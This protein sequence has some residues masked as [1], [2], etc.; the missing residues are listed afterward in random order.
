MSFLPSASAFLAPALAWLLPFPGGGT[1][2]RSSLLA[3]PALV[4]S[5]ISLTISL[6]RLWFASVRKNRL[7]SLMTCMTSR[8]LLAR[9][10]YK[11]TH[12][13]LLNITRPCAFPLRAFFFLYF[14][15][16]VTLQSSLSRRSGSA[17]CLWANMTLKMV[18]AL[19]LVRSDPNSE[20]RVHF[21][22][23][24]KACTSGKRIAVGAC[25]LSYSTRFEVFYPPHLGRTINAS[26]GP[27]RYRGQH[28]VNRFFFSLPS[29]QSFNEFI[30][31]QR[32]EKLLS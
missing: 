26:F 27:H 7:A 23:T 18:T 1:L 13:D 31:I 11:I 10:G 8:R 21:I 19:L 29:P 25:M 32:R 20:S 14:E 22:I 6:A 2:A 16:I 28:F 17:H 5:P 15:R 4:L 24:N 12:T 30:R 3:R 9:G